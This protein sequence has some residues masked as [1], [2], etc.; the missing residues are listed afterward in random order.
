MLKQITI[1]IFIFLLTLP[2]QAYEP[3]SQDLSDYLKGEGEVFIRDLDGLPGRIYPE[4][5]VR[6]FIIPYPPETE[7]L[8]LIGRSQEGDY[9]NFGLVE[10]NGTYNTAK[11]YPFYDEEDGLIYFYSQMPSSAFCYCAKYRWDKEKIKL[12]LIEEW[13]EDPSREA[14]EEIEKFLTAGEIKKAEEKLTGIMYPGNYYTDSELAVKFL[15]SAHKKAVEDYRNGSNDSWNLIFY[16]LDASDYMGLNRWIFSFNSKEGYEKSEFKNYMGYEDFIVIVN[17]Y[18]FLLEQAERL[19]DA[20]YVLEYTIKLSPDRT[21]AY[22]NLGDALYKNGNKEEAAEHYSTYMELMKKE[23]N[24]E[25]IP[26][27]VYERI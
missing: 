22:L 14:M 17:D 26:D 23:K 25:N 27:R 15:K 13:T 9:Y 20:I 10:F 18:G 3:V 1:I 24:E 19:K 16:S 2:L 4:N 21:A 7:Q 11:T 8:F 12:V 6:L 5:I